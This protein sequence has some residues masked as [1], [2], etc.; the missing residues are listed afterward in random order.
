MEQIKEKGAVICGINDLI[1]PVEMVDNPR[2]TNPEYAKVV[3]GIV[4]GV[5][6][7]LNYC[8]SRY[9]LIPNKDIFPQ[10][11]EI[12]NSNGIHYSAGYS[13][14]NHVRFYANY[15]LE[16]DNFGYKLKETNDLIYPRL[17]VQHSY[18]GLTKYSIIFGYFRLIC[19][20]GLTIPLTE[21][22][23]F[24]LNIVGKHTEHIQRSFIV[25]NERLKFFANNARQVTSDIVQKYELL[26]GRIVENPQDRI[27]EIL[28]ANK[29]SI[30]ENNKFNTMNDIIN[31]LQVEA[32]NPNLGYNGKVNDWLI[33]NAINQYIYS[34][35]TI[36]A[37]EFKME[38]DTKI[39][40]YILEH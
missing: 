30:V 40:N 21:M 22:S 19:S 31:R 34:P 27:T 8:S 24:N 26:G 4:D 14:I 33:Y 6:M 37:P 11:E 35:R 36:A 7:D 5:E 9:A 3:R 23:K 20:N 18:N 25:L 39:L 29:I 2:P 28:K 10:I 13:H 15:T 32:N 16:D 1:F 12:L 17:F 38:K